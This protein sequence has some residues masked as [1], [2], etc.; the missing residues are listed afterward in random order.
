MIFKHKQQY[1]GS[2]PLCS[3]EIY[4]ENLRS[5]NKEKHEV[6][7]HLHRAKTLEVEIEAQREQLDLELQ[8]LAIQKQMIAEGDKEEFKKALSWIQEKKVLQINVRTKLLTVRQVVSCSIF[9]SCDI[10]ASP[11]S[12]RPN[13]STLWSESGCKTNKLRSWTKNFCCGTK[14][15]TSVFLR[16]KRILS[17]K[18]RKP[19]RGH[20]LLQ[21][22]K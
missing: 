4:L 17:R 1:L 15:S 7:L 22:L 9:R 6:F 18:S 16:R 11:N 10:S 14:I 3:E 21:H 12:R 20:L 8:N 5:I 2:T 19:Y 13:C